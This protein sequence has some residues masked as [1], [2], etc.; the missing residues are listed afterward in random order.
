MPH[1]ATILGTRWGIFFFVVSCVG[2]GGP[3][4]MFDYAL[5]GSVRWCSL[6]RVSPSSPGLQTRL[7]R[8]LLFLLSR[9]CG[10]SLFQIGFSVWD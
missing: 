2:G 8:V 4:V 10:L 7:V 6:P 9:G 3:V 5:I 1:P